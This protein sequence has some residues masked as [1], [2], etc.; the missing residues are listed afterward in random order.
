[1]HTKRTIFKD[2]IRAEF[3]PPNPSFTSKLFFESNQDKVMLYAAGMPAMPI[4]KYL[5]EFFSKKGY[6]AIH[7]RYRGCW[8]SEGEFLAESPTR[9]ILDVIEELPKGFPSIWEDEDYTVNPSKVVVVG[10][11]FGG[12]AAILSTLSDQVDKA[13]CFAPVVD[14]TAESDGEPHDWL[15]SVVDKAYGGAYN[16]NKEDWDKLQN[17]KFF[18]PAAKKDELDGDDIMIFHARDDETVLFEPV[19]EFS[20]EIDCKFVSKKEGGHLSVRNI[21]RFFWWWKVRSFIS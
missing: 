21:K 5:L 2:K 3:L 8:E 15:Y 14:W 17:G 19:K 6:W 11:S 18:N 7:P 10:S 9:D 4:K 13:V 16:V 1:M 12:A 20:Q